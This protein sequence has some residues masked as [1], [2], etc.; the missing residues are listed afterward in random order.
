MKEARKKNKEREEWHGIKEDGSGSDDEDSEEGG[1]D[2]VQQAK[3]RNDSSSSDEDSDEDGDEPMDTIGQKRSRP[4]EAEE[5]EKKKPRLVSKLEDPKTSASASRATDLW[6]S[7]DIF[8]GLDPL[9]DIRDEESDESDRDA[10]PKEEVND[11]FFKNECFLIIYHR[12]L[13]VMTTTSRLFP[14]TRIL[15]LKCGMQPRRTRMK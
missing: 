7:Q 6:F 8:N 3:G 5:R 11:K 2:E 10:S 1:W 13:L 9:D 14:K 12:C 4:R 15:I